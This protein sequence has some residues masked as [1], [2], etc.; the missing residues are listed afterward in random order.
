M[1]AG[2]L[3]LT[4]SKSRPAVS[5]P[6]TDTQ[7]LQLHHLM[8]VSRITDERALI[9]HKQ[10]RIGFYVPAIGEEAAEVGSVFAL[11]PEDW[12]FPDYRGSGIALARE[13]PL[14]VFFDQVLGN[15]EDVLKGH[16]MPS[17]WGDSSLN[18]VTPSSPI[19]THLSHAV[20]VAWAAM[21]KREKMVTISYFGDGGTSSG[22]FH[23][24]MNLAG[25]FK[26][27]T[28]FFCRNNQYAISVPVDR[29]TAVTNLAEKASAYGVTGVR[30]DGNDVLAVYLATKE[31][32]QRALRG[33]GP[34]FIE[35]V[36]YRLGPHTTIDDPTKY[37]GKTEEENAWK[38]DPVLRFSK[39]LTTLG[40]W[41]M[42]KDQVLRN[43]IKEDV[44]LAITNA[45]EAPKPEIDSLFDDV[46]GTSPWHLDEQRTEAKRFVA[47]DRQIQ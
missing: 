47:S 44:N 3:S 29:Q 1:N 4:P 37:R 45:Q 28:I 8:I 20:G 41:D 16:S 34:T 30:V 35:A 25:V 27:P 7:L 18:I 13:M 9:A 2:S 12:I 17:H 10:G 21:M 19:C 23:G 36:T 39:Y 5:S 11:S 43:K 6:L 33:D 46:Y 38:R 15:I 22:E 14:K 42:E 26:I 24:A 32:R 40:L 31:A